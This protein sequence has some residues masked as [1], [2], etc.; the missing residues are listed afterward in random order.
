MAKAVRAFFVDLAERAVLCAPCICNMTV[1]TEYRVLP[2]PNGQGINRPICPKLSLFAHLPRAE[3][4]KQRF[5]SFLR[6]YGASV[7]LALSSVKPPF[8]P[9]QR[10]F[11]LRTNR[12]SL[13]ALVPSGEQQKGNTATFMLSLF[14]E[15]GN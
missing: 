12:S 2:I 13:I 11:G 15:N 5:P 14:P 9:N 3:G 6:V 10:P 1:H 4:Q 8:S 7:Q